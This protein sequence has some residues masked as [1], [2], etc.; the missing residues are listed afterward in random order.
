MYEISKR[1]SSETVYRIV[2]N[3]GLRERF[4]ERIKQQS[5]DP[6]HAP[7]QVHQLSSKKR[8]SAVLIPLV[9][10][11]KSP[12]IIFTHRSLQLTSHR[13]EISFPGGRLEPGETYEQVCLLDV[14][15]HFIF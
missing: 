1:W 5:M 12:S 10:I 3:E 9:Y 15:F 13:G 14:F 4:C 6:I 7:Y 2:L 8:E 11:Q